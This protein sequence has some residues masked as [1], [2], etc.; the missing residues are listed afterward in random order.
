MYQLLYML[1]TDLG[2][3]QSKAYDTR[4]YQFLETAKSEII[5]EG[6]KNLNID[7]PLDAQLVV[8]YAKW[9]WNRRR[10]ME[11]MPRMLR[12]RLNNRV[13]GEKART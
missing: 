11:G 4:L 7:D 9:L 8:D 5:A 13:M 3:M 2:I 12:Y 6:A 10:S 1:K